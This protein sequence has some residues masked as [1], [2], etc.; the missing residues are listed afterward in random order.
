[1][2]IEHVLASGARVTLKEES[3]IALCCELLRFQEIV[4]LTLNTLL[5]SFL[6][7]Y[8]YN[9][10][11]KFTKFYQQCKVIHQPEQSSRLLI[12]CAVE[13]VLRLGYE[14]IGIGFLERI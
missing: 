6:C 1:V 2:T 12:I 11:V 9:L 4:E 13:R 7:D 10:C 14:L 5:P 8:L 3:E